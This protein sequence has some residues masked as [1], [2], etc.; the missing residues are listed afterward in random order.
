MPVTIPAGTTIQGTS[1]SKLNCRCPIQLEGDNVTIKNIELLF[2]STDALGSVPHREIFLAGHSLTL[3]NVSTYL[4]GGEGGFGS[5]TGTE[6]EL[7]PTVMAGGYTGTSV[8]TNAALTIIRSNAKTMFQDIYMGHEEGKY[9]NVPYTGSAVLTLDNLATV[10][11]SVYTDKNTSARI[12]LNGNGKTI[13]N[14]AY[15]TSYVGNN[16]T[17]LTIADC[18]VS[19]ASI[20][21]VGTIQLNQ[22]AYLMPLTDQFQNISLQDSACLDLTELVNIRV[23]GNFSGGTGAN[24]SDAGM[25][26]LD[27]EGT[28]TIEGVVEGTTIFQTENRNFPGIP[29]VGKSYI[30]ADWEEAGDENFIIPEKYVND[31]YKMQYISGAWTIYKSYSDEEDFIP[32]VGDVIISQ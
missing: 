14:S 30:I 8:G 2:E 29:I 19:R 28:L 6:K 7:L 21:G 32:E 18:T 5:L 25:I 26:V 22:N 16:D 23:S 15:A 3:D 12:D 11:G 4:K 1:G 27:K 10:R 9:Q 24:V 31:G 17:I 13:V 20:D